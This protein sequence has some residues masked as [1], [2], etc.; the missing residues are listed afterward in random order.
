MLSFYQPSLRSL[1]FYFISYL[2]LSF[3]SYLLVFLVLLCSRTGYADISL[4]FPMNLRKQIY[5]CFTLSTTE[6]ESL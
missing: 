1:V 5:V 6:L 2:V 4:A 3:C